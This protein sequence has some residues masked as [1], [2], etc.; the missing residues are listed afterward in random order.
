LMD[1]TPGKKEADDAWI[2]QLSKTIYS[3]KREQAA[4]AVAA[5]LS[6]GYSP[7]VIGEAMS[8]AC[9]RL[10]LGDPGRGGAASPAKPIGSVHGASVGVHASDSANAWRHIARVSNARNT[11]ASLI[12]GAFHT[13][14]QT[15]RQMKDFYPHAADLETV[16]EKDA[17]ALL[18]A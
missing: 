8:L 3:Q 15:G 1:K 4:E 13:A 18:H 7:E 17:A 5:V 9:A 2:D 10:G 11:F 16:R 6:E 12:A 14:G